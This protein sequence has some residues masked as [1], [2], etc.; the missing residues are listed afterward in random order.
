MTQIPEG[1]YPRRDPPPQELEDLRNLLYGKTRDSLGAYNPNDWNAA[2]Q[3]AQNAINQQ[4]SLLGSIPTALGQNNGIAAEIAQMARTGNIP[5]GVQNRLNQSVNQG[6]QNSMGTMLNNYANKG[7]IN[8]SIASQGINNLSQEAADAYNRNYLSAYQAALSGLGAAM[9]GGQANAQNTLAAVNALGQIPSQA[10]EGAGASLTPAYNMWKTWQ[11][12]YD[13]RTDYDYAVEGGGGGG[14]SC[15]TGNTRVRL[16]NG[17]EIPVSELKE[18]NAIMTWDFNGGYISHGL[19][20]AFFKNHSDE[21][22]DVIRV[23]FED[24]SAVEVIKEHLFFDM[25]ER[26]FVAVNAE[27][28]N[29]IGHEFAK[30][31]RETEE[32]KP[33]KVIDI[34]MDGKVYDAYAP[35]C[36][37]SYNFLA[38]DFITAN[39][40]QLALCNMFK[41]DNDRMKFDYEAMCEDLSKYPLLKYSQL[42]GIV[43]KDFFYA[44]RGW[45]IGVAIG[46]GLITLEQL[47]G[48]LAELSSCF[49]DNEGE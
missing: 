38:N 42:E 30:F 48:Y 16:E 22:F 10:Y 5:S 24:G 39:D 46:K 23:E 29:Y 34:L 36:A 28:M 13:M 20:T 35:Q 37:G 9:Q 19:L 32:V 15:V 45:E 47:K 41:F 44:N 31:D 3:T 1:A 11:T 2:R 25:N 4:N 14:S 18:G 26:K 6:L 40:G 8:S 17:E 7:V 43:N 33:V 49:I 27:S 21:G 12:L